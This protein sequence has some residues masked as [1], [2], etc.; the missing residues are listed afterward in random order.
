MWP[1]PISGAAFKVEN[2]SR[3]KGNADYPRFAMAERVGF[4]PTIPLQVCCISSA[5]HSTTEP[6]FKGETSRWYRSRSC[7]SVVLSRIF[8]SGAAP[9]LSTCASRSRAHF[10]ASSFV[11]KDL[12]RGFKPRRRTC[13]CQ[14]PLSFL[15]VAMAISNIHCRSCVGCPGEGAKDYPGAAITRINCNRKS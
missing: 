9:N 10:S 4:E 15:I 12:H 13:A 3:I 5:V 2:N 8:V 14:R 7:P 6:R 11:S 1:S